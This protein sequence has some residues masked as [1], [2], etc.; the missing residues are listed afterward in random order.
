MIKL[1]KFEKRDYDRLIGWI[2]SEIS[3]IQFSGPVFNFPVTYEQLDMYAGA[4]NRL[5]FRVVDANTSEVIGHAE[6]NQIDTKNSSARICR[7]LIGNKLNRNK[8]FGK[9]IVKELIRIGFNDLN[10]HRLDLGVFDFNQ[11]AIKCYAGCGFEIEGLFIEN[12]KVG[13]EYWS[14]YNMSIINNEI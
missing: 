4:A 1:E 5:V 14:T 3:M 10:L 7:L 11:Q 8:G 2:D 12:T 9:A 6:L 13:D